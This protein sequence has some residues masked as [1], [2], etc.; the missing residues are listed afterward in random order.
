MWP[1]C[2]YSMYACKIV[3]LDS[4]LYIGWDWCEVQ[5]E[6][7]CANSWSYIN[8]LNINP[9]PYQL[10]SAFHWTDLDIYVMIYLISYLLQINSLI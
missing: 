1:M 10:K 2:M 9:K 5:C 8:A 6:K 4:K 3:T 7:P